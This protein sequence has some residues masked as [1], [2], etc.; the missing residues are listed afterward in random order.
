MDYQPFV[1][2][3]TV[4]PGHYLS[5]AQTY[6]ARSQEYQADL[7]FWDP[8][9]YSSNAILPAPVPQ[10]YEEIADQKLGTYQNPDQDHRAP[11]R[12]ENQNE[13]DAQHL[14]GG[15]VEDMN[16]T[17]PNPWWCITS[18]KSAEQPPI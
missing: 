17:S 4:P 7:D 14:A 2:S 13:T 8:Q 16:F 3:R 12:D 18:S 10:R 5:L 11:P 9:P 15:L 6:V 1:A